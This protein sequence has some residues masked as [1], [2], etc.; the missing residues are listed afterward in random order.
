MKEDLK[1]K[2]EELIRGYE[3]Q[4]RRAAA[5]E[6]DYQSREEQLS[7]HGHWSL[8]YHGARADLYADVIDDLRQCLEEAEEK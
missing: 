2:I 6:A 1:K 3:R 7:S 8:G 5:K 4:Q